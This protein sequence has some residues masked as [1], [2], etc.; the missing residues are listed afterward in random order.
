MIAAILLKFTR[1][2][3]QK[4]NLRSELSTWS[5]AELQRRPTPDSWNVTDI[6]DHLIKIEEP[7]PGSVRHT[8][9]KQH[10]VGLLDH[11]ALKF[12]NAVAGSRLRVKVPRKGSR[13]LPDSTES[14]AEIFARWDA[15]RADIQ[16]S[17]HTVK[18]EQLPYGLYLH[19]F[20]F[21]LTLD[22]ALDLVT[23]HIRHHEYQFERLKS[24]P[25]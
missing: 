15:V 2:E 22:G 7:L 9:P 13:F 8:L 1:L 18:A 19:P 5:E 4:L 17:L 3:Q 24:L 11:A 21:W 10:R 6:L 14:F 23:A 25:R 16:R 20:G 12:V